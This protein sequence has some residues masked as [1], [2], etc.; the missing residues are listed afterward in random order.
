MALFRCSTMSL[1]LLC[2]LQGCGGSRG[3]SSPDDMEI[4]GDCPHSTPEPGY[5]VY[6][7]AGYAVGVTD[8]AEEPTDVQ[9]DLKALADGF[10][11]GAEKQR[12]RYGASI[13]V[14]PIR[15]PIAERD[16]QGVSVRALDPAD[17]SEIYSAAFAVIVG[18][19]TIICSTSLT[20]G[21]SKCAKV[22]D[23]FVSDAP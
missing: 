15:S 6:E 1:A 21:I 9:A 14:R 3:A 19:R 10:I 2:G 8:E 22:L 4:V 5:H 20:M 16:V 23:A 12:E 18:R 11:A 17:P 7:C 13:V